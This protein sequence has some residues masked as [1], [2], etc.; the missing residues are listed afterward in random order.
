MSTTCVGGGYKPKP[1]CTAS[2][3]VGF[4]KGF[5]K[6]W[7]RTE[8]ISLLHVLSDVG[9]RADREPEAQEATLVVQNTPHPDVLPW[10]APRCGRGAMGRDSR[11]AWR[12]GAASGT[13]VFEEEMSMRRGLDALIATF[14]AV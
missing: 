9:G 14:G 11:H 2:C 13:C 4:L 8:R 7:R 3:Q 12:D 10:P 6:A 5:C 1:G